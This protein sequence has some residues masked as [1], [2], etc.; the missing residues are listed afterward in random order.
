[1]PHIGPESWSWEC[2]SWAAIWSRIRVRVCLGATTT[3]SP[4]QENLFYT[5]LPSPG[6][7]LGISLHLSLLKTCYHD[8]LWAGGQRLAA[9]TVQTAQ[10]V[11]T[12]S[13]TTFIIISGQEDRPVRNASPGYFLRSGNKQSIKK[14][15]KGNYLEL[16]WKRSSISRLGFLGYQINELH[17]HTRSEYCPP[18]NPGWFF[19][20]LLVFSL[21]AGVIFLVL[22]SR[23]C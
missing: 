9:K 1:M 16:S 19:L 3:S 11:S 20:F 18:A 6:S 22:A 2:S 14:K 13:R 7:T 21:S 12:L 4:C 10:H 5:T 15:K 23:F 8:C 17:R